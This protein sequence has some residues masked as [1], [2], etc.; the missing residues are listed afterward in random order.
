MDGT[1]AAHR[2][3]DAGDPQWSKLSVIDIA[4][5]SLLVTA[6]LIWVF[7]AGKDVNFDLLNYHFYLPFNMLDGRLEREFMAANAQGYQNPL[8]YLPFYLMVINGWRSLLIASVLASV[9]SLAIVLAYLIGK[10]TLGAH[11]RARSIAALGALLAFASPVFLVEAGTTFADVT[12]AVF[13]LAAVLF[14]LRTGEQHRSLWKPAF[15]AGLMLGIGSGLK[16]SNLVFG[17]ACALLIAWR[18]GN[19]KS[20]SQACFLFGLA[21]VLGFLS[22]YGY[23]GWQLWRE[24]GNPFFPLFNDIFLSPDFPAVGGTHERFTPHTLGDALLLPFRMLELRSW[25]YI[26]SVAPDLRFAFLTAVV[27]A[28]LIVQV[29]RRFRGILSEKAQAAPHALAAFTIVAFGFWVFSSANGRYGIAVSIICGPALAAL[30]A[31][32]IKNS[33]VVL[34]ALTS[35]LALQLFHVDKGDRRWSVEKWTREWFDLEIPQ[36]LTEQAFLYIS[37]GGNTNS[38]V[39]PFLAPD[40]V[41]MNPVGLVS[42]EVDGPGGQRVKTLLERYKGRIRVIALDPAMEITESSFQAWVRSA[43]TM[44]ARLGYA[45]DPSNCEVIFSAGVPYE[46]GHDFSNEVPRKRKLRTCLLTPRTFELADKRQRISAVADQIVHWCPKLFKP[47]YNVVE[48]IPDGWFVNYPVSDTMLMFRDDDAILVTQTRTSKD[49][50]LGT[51]ADWETRTQRPD[52]A[53]LPQRP[54]DVY[55]FD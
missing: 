45:V 55:T 21:A 30:T 54:R 43:D 23:W 11:P 53:T 47:A 49:I 40:S 39:L 31:T 48:R 37:V 26:E 3:D 34:I 12:S 20:A 51:L 44:I 25:I 16:L 41:F 38:Y 50:Y 8:P 24:F 7:V 2:F 27:F 52:C 14:A 10:E 19:L 5:I 6:T 33:K 28:A 17:P 4:V 36:H 9:H 22:A 35:L 32:S 18:Q 15:L 42:F 1:P 29:V 13:V 46:P